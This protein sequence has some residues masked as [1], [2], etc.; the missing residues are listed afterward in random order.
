MTRFHPASA[1]PLD[2]PTLAGYW[3]RYSFRLA[4]VWD[5]SWVPGWSP[6]GRWMYNRSGLRG[7]VGWMT[8]PN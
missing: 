2:L 8:S 7:I 3:W 5:D 1:G 4:P 6:Y